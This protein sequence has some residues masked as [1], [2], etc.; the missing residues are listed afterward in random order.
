M[1]RTEF[2]SETFKCLRMFAAIL[3]LFAVTEAISMVLSPLVA[4]PVSVY[5]AFDMFQNVK[6]ICSS[7]HLRASDG[8][9]NTKVLL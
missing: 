7:Q 8:E 5:S 4:M 9:F 6:V 2:R 1:S 3:R